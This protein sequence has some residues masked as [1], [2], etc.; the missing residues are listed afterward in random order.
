MMIMAAFALDFSADTVLS[1][2]LS[3][4]IKSVP[5]HEKFPDASY[6]IITDSVIVK[7][8]PANAYEGEHYFLAKAYTYRGK[9]HLSNYKIQ[10]NANFEEVELLRA[11]TINND[12]IIPIDSLAI[13]EIG[14]PGYSDAGVYAKMKQLV[15]SMPAFSESSVVEIGY[16][17]RS[18]GKV[19]VPFGGMNVLVGE[20]PARNVFFALA[21][22]HGEKL[23]WAS[24][25][26]APNPAVSA[27]QARW[28]ITDW[29]GVQYEPQIPALREIMPTIVYAASASWEDE[30]GKIANAIYTNAVADDKI[31][32]TADSLALG[33]SKS[34][35][36][37]AM[38]FHIQ[39][40][41]EHINISPN[42]IGYEP[43][44]ASKIYEHGYGDSRDLSTLLLA[45]LKLAGV[46]AYPVLVSI[47][48]ASIYDL[49][50]VHQFDRM[51]VMA[52]IDGKTVF[53][54]PMREYAAPGRIGAANGEK[55]F[56]ISPGKARIETVPPFDAETDNGTVIFNLKVAEDAS[57]SGEVITE[58]TGWVSEELREPFRHA[59][60]R[61]KRQLFE[62]AASNVADGAKVV[63]EPKIEGIE[64]NNGVARATIE[65]SAQEFLTM[66]DNMGILWLP[67][68][69]FEIFYMPDISKEKRNFPIYI[70]TPG[71]LFKKYSFYFPTKFDVAYL[72]PSERFENEV[73]VLDIG[74]QS[75]EYS[76]VVNVSLMLKKKRIMPDEYDKL[77]Q[78]I[79]AINAKKYR[80]VLLESEL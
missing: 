13:N 65:I 46:E 52:I 79:G 41:F 15:L 21:F 60:K 38:L 80:I 40:K 56:I 76:F 1:P 51:A 28:V 67:P 5:A 26:G 63:G 34:E 64:A 16:I 69:P 49:P 59:K 32:K 10:F 53:L 77:R 78:L 30:C 11:R 74:S 61:R 25:S 54:D 48:G 36:V 19:P 6:Y 24:L 47:G 44:P 9:K 4:L 70:D 57:I 55:A 68:M 37:Y 75:G 35:I 23:Q 27:G 12:A 8:L 43:N 22:P 31:R 73:G 2:E 14:A 17:I 66:Q 39:E 33:K 18:H 58:A 3:E 50:T 7:A 45:M 72:P 42:L 71:R 20:E 29:K 62:H